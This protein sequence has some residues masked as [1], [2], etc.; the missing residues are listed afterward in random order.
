MSIKLVLADDHNL[1]RAGLQSLIEKETDLQI[2]GQAS[3][4]RQTVSLVQKLKPDIV[5]MDISMPGLNGIEA[6]RQIKAMNENIKV[7][8]LSVHE[9]ASYVRR[10]LKAGASGYLVKHSEFKELVEAIRAV[11]RE[12]LYLSPHVSNQLVQDYLKHLP[13]D[14]STAFSMLS[15]REREI[16]QLLAEGKTKQEIGGIL[17]LSVKTIDSHRLNIMNKLKITTFSDLIRY[18]I[19]EGIS[20]L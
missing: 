18:A 12:Q 20:E 1:I 7:I 16:L 6:T 4:G 2:I 19:R 15:E 14:E 17:F 5:I 3:D 10:M 9:E 13:N 8:A 11:A